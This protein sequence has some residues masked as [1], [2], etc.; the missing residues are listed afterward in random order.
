[1]RALLDRRREAADAKRRTIPVI[2]VDSFASDAGLAA[3]RAL[4]PDLGVVD[5]TNVLKEATFGMPRFGSINLHCGWLPDYRGAPAGFWE[6]LRGERTVGVTIHRVTAAVD[7]GPIL[8]QEATVLDPAPPGD[9]MRY[10]EELRQHTLAPIGVRL[11]EQVVGAI[12]RGEA[13]ERPQGPTDNPTFR[14]P[15][16][17][18]VR[19]L[20]RRVR[21]RRT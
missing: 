15:D 17:K 11:L 18:T 6:L 1:V 8:A 2:E 4:D 5:G 13:M 19:D 3:L 12:A 16:V 20:R 7:A 21:R 10:L 9:P 14:Y